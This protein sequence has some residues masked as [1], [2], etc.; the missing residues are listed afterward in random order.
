MITFEKSGPINN[1]CTGSPRYPP[2]CHLRTFPS[3]IRRFG[4][5]LVVERVY[6]AQY[7]ISRMIFLGRNACTV[8]LY[9]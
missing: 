9:L 5:F 8:R 6:K 2:I 7:L 1:K 3:I 4:L